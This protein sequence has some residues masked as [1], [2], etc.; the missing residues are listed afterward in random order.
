MGGCPMK[1]SC[2]KHNKLNLTAQVTGINMNT[3]ENYQQPLLAFS[4]N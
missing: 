2:S 4:I 1:T 3:V